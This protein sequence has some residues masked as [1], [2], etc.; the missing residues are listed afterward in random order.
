MQELPVPEDS[1]M[2]TVLQAPVYSSPKVT[3]HA[4]L[5]TAI[6][7]TGVPLY[8]SNSHLHL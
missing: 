7:G 5:L 1:A 8:P 2:H 6:K 4:V 3:C